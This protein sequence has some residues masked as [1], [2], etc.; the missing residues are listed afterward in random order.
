V[1]KAAAFE[2]AA[3]GASDPHEAYR[4]LQFFERVEVNANGLYPTK[5]KK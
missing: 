2:K 1:N 5:R 4:A 3:A